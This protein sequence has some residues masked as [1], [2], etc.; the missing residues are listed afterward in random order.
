[1]NNQLPSIEQQ[2]NASQAA[3]ENE[4]EVR[5][6]RRLA[7]DEI[8]TKKEAISKAKAKDIEDLCKGAGLVWVMKMRLGRRT[9][10]IKAARAVFKEARSSPYCT[11]QV[12]EAGGK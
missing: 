9:E 10:G 12:F 1:M 4:G 6:K 8:N 11:W 3:G 7:E 2:A 5:E